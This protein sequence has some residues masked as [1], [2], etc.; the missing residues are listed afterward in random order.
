M[1]DINIFRQHFDSV[2]YR[3]FHSLALLADGQLLTGSKKLSGKWMATPIRWDNILVSRFP[4]LQKYC[5][6]AL[7]VFKKTAR[8]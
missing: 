3:G 6:T 7:L 1:Q 8:G 5:W 4:F 2:T